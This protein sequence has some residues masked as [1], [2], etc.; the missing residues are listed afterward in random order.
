MAVLALPTELPIQSRHALNDIL[1]HRS[2]GQKKQHG[3]PLG[4]PSFLI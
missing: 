4:T 2:F 1:Q 3:S